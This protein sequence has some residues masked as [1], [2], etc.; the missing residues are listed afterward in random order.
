MELAA[1]QLLGAVLTCLAAA[2]SGEVTCFDHQTQD[3][4]SQFEPAQCNQ[5]CTVTPFFSPDHSVDTYL[6]LIQSATESIDLYT[7]GFDS[8]SKC[9]DFAKKCNS[10]DGCAIED[11][12]EEAFPIFPALLNAVHQRGIKIRLLTNNFTTT[13]CNGTINP[14]DWLY[15]NGIQINFYS[16]TTFMH[17]KVV[18]ID[19]GKR[20]SVSSVN[21]SK[22][23]FTKNRE[24]GVVIEDCSCPALDLYQSTF[25]YDWE[26]GFEYQ[27]QSKYSEEEMAVITDTTLMD[28]P[29]ST[30][31]KIPGA[32]VTHKT[33]HTDVL[34]TN[35]YT[36]PDGARDVIM[37]DLD[38][39][40]S[41][42][43]V[44]IY[45]ITDTGI[46]DQLL[47][48]SQRGVN[49][50]IIVSA[51][52]VSYTDW[53]LS[54]DCY[55]SLYNGGMKGEIRKALT[56]F[57]FAHQ[58]YW[59]IDGKAV[60]LSTGNWSPSD[61]PEGSTFEPQSK[62]QKNVNRDMLVSMQDA[63]IVNTFQT[64]FEN[65]WKSGTDWYPK[66]R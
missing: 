42:L 51:R 29:S 17:A 41:S 24:A 10:C 62:T 16:T 30:Y 48:L 1:R 33:T 15:L 4:S 18:I 54:Q 45:Q 64:V 65:D 55:T 3:Y 47:Q 31:P 39:V 61:F 63:S 56:K 36:A 8:W 43:Q 52:I 57:S 7:P 6:D 34:V 19:H 23:S 53:K 46:C 66:T 60:H 20:T 5:K 35:G 9:T 27:M 2:A 21:F 38:N 14:L 40:K 25:Q 11:Q 26:N 59:I 37:A 50:S 49:V 58:K 32:Y 22:T 13:S 12:K 44:A 28:I